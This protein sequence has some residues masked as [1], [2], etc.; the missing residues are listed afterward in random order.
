[1]YIRLEGENHLLVRTV[2]TAE[3]GVREVV[4][5]NLG[6]DPELNLFVSAE[7]GRR[8]EPELWNGITDF[9][10]LQA[11]EN[12]KRRIGNYRPALV[13]IQGKP[14]DRNDQ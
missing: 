2:K 9:H 5:A 3:Q 1:M 10:L 8:K 14:P 12:Y 11:L 6:I 13:V 7:L 4:L